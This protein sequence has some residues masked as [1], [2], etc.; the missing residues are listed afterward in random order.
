MGRDE[1]A[2]IPKPLSRDEAKRKITLFLKEGK[3]VLSG[4]C[5]RDS[6]PKRN[7]SLPD[8]LSVLQSGEIIHE[9]EWDNENGDWK[10]L[11]EG[12]D[13]DDDELKA[14]TVFIDRNLW[15]YIVTVF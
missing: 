10:Y 1:Q 6:M 14:V 5:K 8:I 12:V 9:P 7:V 4:H 2:N 13:L 15:L 11:V 3:V